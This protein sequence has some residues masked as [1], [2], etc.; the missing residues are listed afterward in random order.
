MAKDLA[1]IKNQ[2]LIDKYGVKIIN[3]ADIALLFEG[4][5]DKEKLHRMFLCDSN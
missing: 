5:V 3:R 1:A 2:I 4:F